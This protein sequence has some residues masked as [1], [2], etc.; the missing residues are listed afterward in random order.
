MAIRKRGKIW[1]LYFR[2]NGK[3][4]WIST[5]QTVEA[6]A[7]KLDRA[8]SAR[9]KSSR[10]RRIMRKIYGPDALPEPS[11]SIQP[12]P[13]HKRG[14]VRLADL[15]TIASKYRALSRFHRNA[16]ADFIRVTGLVYAD[17]VTPRI[18]RDYLEK[19]FGAGNGKSYNN[20]RT[21]LNTIFRL[22]LIESG[23]DASPFAALVPRRVTD[24]VSHR[25]ITDA[26]FRRLFTVAEEPYRTALLIGYHTGLRLMDCFRLSPAD[27]ADGWIRITPAKTARFKRAVE[28]P[29]HPEL[30]DHLSR[31]QVSGSD[32][33]CIGAPSEQR[34]AANLRALFDQCG[35]TDTE[36]GKAS[37]HGLRSAFVTRLRER[38]IPEHAIEGLAGHTDTATTNVY[39]RDRKTPL[40]LLEI[41]AVLPEPTAKNV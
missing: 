4:C 14:T 37:F 5:G 8:N 6:E 36:D 17:K 24:T 32:P 11:A 33:Y 20:A 30:A 38:G 1:Y 28:I 2:E 22:T 19:R 23:L 10:Q 21:Y 39:S 3:I 12:E 9:L 13:E 31:L 26:E 15:F 18:A 40:K 27:I 29:V 16:V 35:V 25:P 7:R 41:P 34:I